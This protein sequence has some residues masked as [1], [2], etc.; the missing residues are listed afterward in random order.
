MRG[1]NNPS[2]IDGRSYSATYNAGS[3][4]HE[5]RKQVYKRDNYNCQRCGVKCVAKSKAMKYPQHSKRIIQCHHITPYEQTQDNSLENL[6]TLCIVCHRAVHT[7]M[8][9]N[10]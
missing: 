8:S 1:K 4:W 6:I 2:Y 7:E 10:G 9:S 5:I 3:N